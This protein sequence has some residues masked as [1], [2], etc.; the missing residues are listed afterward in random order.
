MEVTCSSEIG[1]LIL[2]VLHNV[3]L[4]KFRLRPSVFV[5][6][7]VKGVVEVL[8]SLV[9]TDFGYWPF[10]SIC[11]DG[12]HSFPMSF[13]TFGGLNSLLSQM[14]SIAVCQVL[15]QGQN[16]TFS[17]LLGCEPFPLL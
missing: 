15:S 2:H 1:R 12:F 5:I 11:E 8:L 9:I 13:M 10:A 4:Q 16:C 17:G 6:P 14:M 3:F 7:E